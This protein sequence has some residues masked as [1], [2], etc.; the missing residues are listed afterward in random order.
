[1]KKFSAGLKKGTTRKKVCT[2][3]GGT[4]TFT[5]LSG[6]KKYPVDLSAVVT[7]ADS[8]GSTGRL[9]DEFGYLP[10]G[11]FR[12]ALAALANENG[13]GNILRDLFLYRFEKGEGLTGHNFGNLLLV[14]MADLFGSEVAAIERASKVLRVEGM[15]VPVSDHNVQLVAEYANGKKVVGETSIDEPPEGH[16]GAM[17]IAKLSLKPRARIHESARQAI[18]EADI[19]ILGP[20]DLYTSTIANLVVGGVREAIA[21]SRAQLVFVMNLMTKYGQTAGFGAREHVD[22]IARY[23]GKI[24]DYVIV[25]NEPLPENVSKRYE[26]E[27]DFPVKD[28]LMD[29]TSAVVRAPLLSSEIIATKKG[30]TVRRSLIRHDSDKLAREIMGLL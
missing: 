18:E 4:G 6:L 16:D 12:M 24:P 26:K 8:G 17:R 5:V 27:R 22:E 3:G 10:V 15:V 14:A 20:G 19:L 30:D 11:D 25:N 1:M 28:D 21:H 9:R 13:D 29:F 7:V 23:A 2:I